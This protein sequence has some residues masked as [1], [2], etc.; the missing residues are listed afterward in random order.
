LIYWWNQL[1][2]SKCI[3]TRLHTPANGDFFS[4]VVFAYA[5]TLID[6]INVECRFENCRSKPQGSAA[7]YGSSFSIEPSLH[8]RIRFWNLKIQ[9]S[10]SPNESWKIRENSLLPWAASLLLCQ[11]LDGCLFIYESEFWFYHFAFASTTGSS[12]A[13]IRKSRCLNYW[14]NATKFKPYLMKLLNYK[15]LPSGYHRDFIIVK[16]KVCFQPFKKNLL[17]ICDFAIKD[18]KV[19]TIFLPIKNTIIYSQ[20][21]NGSSWECL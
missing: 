6:D 12:I 2:T 5:E 3:V 4:N 18:I 17:R 8:S 15:Q 11:I 13:T 16:R 20:D 7:G 10:C 14:G 1:K 9:F 19:K 21:A